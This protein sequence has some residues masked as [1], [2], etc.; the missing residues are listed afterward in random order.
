MTDT[1][2]LEERFDL[3]YVRRMRWPDLVNRCLMWVV[4]LGGGG[5]LAV[6]SVRGDH[7]L[8]SSGELH[9][10]HASLGR[11]CAQCH[12]PAPGA[13][14]NYFLPV[15]DDACLRCH[16]AAEHALGQSA[17]SADFEVLIPGHAAPVRMAARCAEC[18][19]EHRGAHAD[20]NLVPDR[21]CLQCHADLGRTGYAERVGRVG[22][23]LNV[24][25]RP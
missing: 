20:L 7:R 12:Q 14:V 3:T 19:V 21:V 22:T 6:L 13:S 1:R 16:A 24:E 25:Q 11:D 8:Y 4:V 15:S 23:E 18:H 5:A 9:V 17:F 2:P 10:V